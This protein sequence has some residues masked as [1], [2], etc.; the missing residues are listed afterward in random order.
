VKRVVNHLI[1][2]W[3]LGPSFTHWQAFHTPTGYLSTNNP[4]ETYHFTLK[5]V[6][7]DKRAN[8]T[9]LVSRLDLSRLGYVSAMRGFDNVPSVSKRLKA[10][11]NRAE[12]M[13]ELEAEVVHRLPSAVMVRIWRRATGPTHVD[14]D[15]GCSF[16][17]RGRHILRES[18]VFLI[19]LRS[20]TRANTS[21]VR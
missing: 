18:L 11:F 16:S 5:L 6:N 21:T 3:L 2:M 7:H 10:A 13:H 4:L 9:E 1:N 15:E 19:T 20:I 14:E 12:K 17:V 8:S